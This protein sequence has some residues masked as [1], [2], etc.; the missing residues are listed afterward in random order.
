MAT[1]VDLT[2]AGRTYQVAC[3]EGEEE[4]LRSAGRLV[5]GKAREALAG[6]GT[7][8]EARQF[9]FASLLLAD[10]WVDDGF[11]PAQRL[12]VAE[13]ARAQ[14]LHRTF[15]R[16]ARLRVKLHLHQMRHQVDDVNLCA[17][18]EQAARGFQ[19]QQPAANDR[20]A[21]TARCILRNRIAI[22]ERAKN[23]NPL[24]R[25]HLVRRARSNS[26]SLFFDSLLVERATSAATGVVKFVDRVA[27]RRRLVEIDSRR[28]VDGARKNTIAGAA[29]LRGVDRVANVSKV[30][31]I[32]A[33]H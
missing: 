3:R 19:P 26:R 7:L 1:M 14:R 16:G 28:R 10:Q 30:P 27:D 29:H 6:L 18:I 24:P 2:I 4:N 20:R 5:D 11:E 12:L 33:S 32:G 13:H 15:E 21:L 31:P 22:V 25:A 9:L 17:Q 23:K 8:S